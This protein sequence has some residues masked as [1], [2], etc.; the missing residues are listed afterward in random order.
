VVG[1][2]ASADLRRQALFA[3]VYATLCTVAYIS[4]R[5]AGGHHAYERRAC[6]SRFLNAAGLVA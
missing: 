2:Q 6:Q 4:W 3:L 1:A 5:F